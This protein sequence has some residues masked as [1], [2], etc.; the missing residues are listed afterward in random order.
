MSPSSTRRTG[1]VLD[2][3]I[4]VYNEER[5]LEG[6]VRRV[7]AFLDE[8]VPFTA[9]VTIADNASVDA[10]WAI[11]EHLAATVPGITAV[12]LDQKGRGR[13]LKQ[14]WLASDAEVVAYMDVDLSTDLSALLPLV[15][16]LVSGHSQVAIGTRLSSDSHVRR[17]AKRELISRSYN[18]MLRT[19]LQAHFSDV[20]CGFKAMRADAAREL[21][22]YV[23][24]TG[25][26]FDTEVLVLAEKAGL[27]IHEVPVDWTDDPDTRVNI[28]ETAK[29]DVEGMIRVARE[30]HEERIPLSEIRDRLA[31]GYPELDPSWVLLGQVLRFGVVGVVC[32]LAHALL[33]WWW[34]G[35]MGAVLGNTLALAT[36]AVLNTAMNRGFTFGVRGRTD[37]AR[38]HAQ[39]LAVFALAWCLTSG[40][41]VVL[42]ALWPGAARGVQF[43]VVVVGNLVAT[44]LHFTLLK[45][46]VFAGPKESDRDLANA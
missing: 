38:H 8:Q 28:Y 27:R 11:A 35:P 22:P 1:P 5:A 9:R 43:A 18:L 3:V 26:F 16:P 45:H 24:D 14:V 7:R 25:W 40:A 33:F 13:A 31:G 4:P 30:L 23:E 41:L 37:L 6:S 2:V 44:I 34:A 17:G 46:W 12:H 15:T 21:L 32:T 10:T 29:A 20:Q 42:D 19:G 39:G 36:T